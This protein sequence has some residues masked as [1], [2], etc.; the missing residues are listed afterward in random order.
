MPP[1]PYFGVTGF[2]SPAEVDN[3]L[4]SYTTP[5]FMNPHLGNRQ[6][7][8]GVLVSHKTLRGEAASSARYPQI[9]RV[10][11][12][13]AAAAKK[14]QHAVPLAEWPDRAL[15][16]VWDLKQRTVR[17]I[18][19]NTAEP[20]LPAQLDRLLEI[21]GPHLSGIQLNI[22]WP[23]ANELRAWKKHHAKRKLRL[24]I[25]I[26][27]AM[28]ASCG[29]DPRALCEK[30]E[31]AYEDVATD[32]LFDL[33]GGQGASP[34]REETARAL[35]ALCARFGT[36]KNIGLAGGLN[37]ASALDLKPFFDGWPWLSIDAESKLRDKDDRLSGELARYYLRNAFGVL[38]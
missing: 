5:A 30:L 18:H 25:Q 29:R 2:T 27:E 10:A 22:A 9:K 20:Q 35:S 36:R 15:G 37:H 34:N 3:V 14:T 8:V 26:N 6:L 32:F 12:I 31:R 38:P 24:V 1:M 28:F 7:M 16:P 21:G 13:F 17:L 19:Y 4:D 33:S 23:A 11:S